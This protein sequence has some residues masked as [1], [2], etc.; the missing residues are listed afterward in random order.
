MKKISDTGFSLLETIIASAITLILIA[1]ALNLFS[2]IPNVERL[3]TQL[4]LQQQTKSALHLMSKEIM[5]ASNVRKT[6]VSLNKIA[7]ESLHNS[8]VT[9]VLNGTNLFRKELRAGTTISQTILLSKIRPATTTDPLFSV[10][11]SS[12]IVISLFLTGPRISN[13]EIFAHFEDQVTN[14]NGGVR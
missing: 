14:R 1:V 13:N 2:N 4:G 12:S 7:F 3:N 10:S 9:Y 11:V 6:D 8:T 5:E